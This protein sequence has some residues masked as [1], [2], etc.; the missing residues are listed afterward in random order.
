MY[1]PNTLYGSD[2]H[3]ISKKKGQTD[4]GLIEVMAARALQ[5]LIDD[6]RAT[7]IEVNTLES[8]RYGVRLDIKITD[9]EGNVEQIIFTPVG[10]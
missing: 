7:T 4:T 5:P 1:A 9:A 10:V 6:G 8:A 3:L 2:F